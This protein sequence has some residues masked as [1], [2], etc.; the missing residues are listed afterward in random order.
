MATATKEGRAPNGPRKDGRLTEDE[1][2]RLIEI[3]PCHADLFEGLVP[4]SRRPEVGAAAAR[5][6]NEPPL[7][8]PDVSR[9]TIRLKNDSGHLSSVHRSALVLVA[10]SLWLSP[11]RLSELLEAVFANGESLHDEIEEWWEARMGT[12][13]SARKIRQKLDV[14]AGSR[15]A[16]TETDANSV[17]VAERMLYFANEL[18]AETIGCFDASNPGWRAQ[19]LNQT[20]IDHAATS[21]NPTLVWAATRIRTAFEQP[22][23]ANST[24]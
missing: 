9:L 19:P 13:V 12:E 21:N 17:R 5:D 4:P 14:L 7:N 2:N 1:R 22:G 16:L 18:D 6:E 24:S 15:D 3:W 10:S 23:E 20:E 11:L 8:I